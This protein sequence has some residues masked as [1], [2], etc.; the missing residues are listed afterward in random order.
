MR[1]ITIV[2]G[3]LAGSEAALQLADRGYEVDLIEMRPSVMTEAHKTPYLAE[4]VCSNSLKSTRIENASGLLKKELNML[5]CR[6]LEIADKSK[7]PAGHALAVDRELFASNVSRVV[8]EHKLINLIED[9]KRDIQISDCSVIATGPLTSKA[10]SKSIQDHFSK[11]HLFFYDAISISINIE[12]V[13]TGIMFKASRYGKGE[14]DYFNIP[15][16]REEYYRLV[17]FLISAPQTEKHNFESSSYFEACLPVE[18][19][20]KRGAE[21]LRYGIM[22][23]KGLIDPSTGMEPYAVIQ[24]RQETRS[25]E[26]YGLVGFQSRLTRKAQRELMAII[27]GL[28]NSEILR[29]ASIHRNTYIDSPRLLDE[30]QMSK[31]RD[32]LFFAGQITGVEGYVESIAHGL[33]ISRNVIAYLKGEESVIFPKE[34]ILGAIQ[35]YLIN[36]EINFQPINANFGL[37]PK[38]KGNKRE[39]KSRKAQIAI[40]SMTAF[41]RR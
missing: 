5:G 29:W 32:G 33:I 8:Q 21:T 25:G 34:T 9:E 37:L 28:E 13:D 17:E 22:K 10:L 39:R 40:D 20:A 4:L 31:M 16:T 15:F 41:L 19:A 12:T 26:M 24:L 7:V 6:L 27:P 23:P 36:T 2:G 14:A 30:R 18:V 11:D 1:K 3:G 35:R 38:V